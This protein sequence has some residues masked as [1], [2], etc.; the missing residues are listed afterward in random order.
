MYRLL[1]EETKEA[2]FEEG[3]RDNE[4][5]FRHFQLRHL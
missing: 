1:N 3:S 4:I 2:D 5:T